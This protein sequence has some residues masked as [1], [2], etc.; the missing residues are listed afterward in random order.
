ME[1]ISWTDREKL[2]FTEDKGGERF[3]AYSKKKEGE[4]DWSHLA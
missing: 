1:K 4:L 2:S 3:P